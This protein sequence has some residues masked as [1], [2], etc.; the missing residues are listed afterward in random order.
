MK[1]ESSSCSLHLQLIGLFLSW[2]IKT[3]AF[4]EVLPFRLFQSQ[5]V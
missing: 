1:A 5:F 3:L 4:C 2:Y